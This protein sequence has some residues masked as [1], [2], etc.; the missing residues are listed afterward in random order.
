MSTT[1]GYLRSTKPVQHIVTDSCFS[2]AHLL[3]VV[4]QPAGL[5]LS[6][7]VSRLSR[8]GRLNSAVFPHS[9]SQ[10]MAVSTNVDCSFKENCNQRNRLPGSTRVFFMASAS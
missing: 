4:W 1:T 2:I 7:M 5:S 10:L 3:P 6:L 8:F 9:R